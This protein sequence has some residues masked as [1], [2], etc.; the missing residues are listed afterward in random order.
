VFW[1]RYVSITGKFS[2]V[3]IVIAG[4]IGLILYRSS[5]VIV[6]A[7]VHLMEWIGL[8]MAISLAIPL[9]V[10]LT[11]KGI[12]KERS[13]LETPAEGVNPVT[14]RAIPDAGDKQIEAPAR[15]SVN[16]LDRI[17][18]GDKSGLDR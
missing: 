6:G 10:T 11:Y 18:E 1:F 17:W 3:P 8:I 14:I 4:V 12:R 13:R 15:Y 9:S 16:Y 7:L 5:G 2:F